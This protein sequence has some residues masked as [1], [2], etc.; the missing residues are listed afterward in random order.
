MNELLK[1]VSVLIPCALFGKVG[2]LSAVAAFN[3]SF[4]KVMLVTNGGGIGGTILF[5]YVSAGLLKW[6]E[7][8]K[9]KYFKSHKHP[10]VFTKTNRLVIKAKKRFGLYGIAF[11]TPILL[12]FPLGTFVAERFYKDKRKVIFALSIAV[13]FWNLALYLLFNFFWGVTK[14]I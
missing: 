5:T 10:K 1:I 8:F 11:L 2:M 14:Y 13:I 9:C 3:F 12:S 7:R 6:W 4:W